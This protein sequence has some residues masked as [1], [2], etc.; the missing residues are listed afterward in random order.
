MIVQFLWKIEAGKTRLW[1]I[2]EI[3]VVRESIL[4][5]LV[6]CVGNHFCGHDLPGC[7]VNKINTI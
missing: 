5:Q 7:G 2:Y 4:Y 3:Y 6:D 1:N